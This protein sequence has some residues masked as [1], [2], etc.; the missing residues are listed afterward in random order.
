MKPLPFLTPRLPDPSLIAQDYADIWAAGIFTNSGPFERRFAA[1]LARWIGNDV[2]V[3]VT[4]NAT[5]ATQ[6]ACRELFHA[7]RR[8]AL[9][10]SFT[11]AAVPLALRWSGYEPVLIDIDP[12]SWQPDVAMAERFLEHAGSDVAGILLTNTFGTANSSIERWETLA[13]K[14][15]LSLVIDSAPGFASRYPWGEPLGSR[16]TCEIFSF[17][18]TKTVAIGEGGAVA[19]RDHGVIERINRLKNFGFDDERRSL[20]M[21]LNA[22]LPELSAAIGLRQLDVLA[23]RVARREHVLGWYVS[24]LEPLGCAFQAGAMQTAPPF[25]SVVLPASTQ[26][27]AVGCAL[28]RADIGWRAYYNPPIHRQPSFG[29]VRV[30]EELNVTDD[31]SSR[32]ISLPLD[33]Q[34]TRDDVSRVAGVI[35]DVIGA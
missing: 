9:V 23:E 11:A 8:H 18:A 33:E 5:T 10:A 34:L 2:A 19:A 31:V 20:S 21:G 30:A 3:A 29:G 14:F 1:E 28:T 25:L 7:D 17:H 24:N 13:Q 26:R 16:G 32:I 22:K 6:L 12:E 4:S 35:G 27:D 15:E